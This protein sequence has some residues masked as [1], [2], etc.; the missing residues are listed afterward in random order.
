VI[1]HQEVMD[2]SREFGLGPHVIEKD[3]VLGWILAGIA[4]HAAINTT[5]VFKGGTCLKK[6][7]FETYRFSEDLDFTITKTANLD[8]DFLKTTFSEIVDWVYGETGIEIPSDRLRFDVY[9]N[10]RGKQAIEG[11]IYYRGPLQRRGDMA[12]IK[13]DISND[14]ILVLDAVHREVHH[15]YSDRPVDGIH[16]LSYCFEEVF[17]E[18]IRALGERERPR[19]LYDVVHL[20]RHD[21]MRPDRDLVKNTLQQKCEFKG[22]DVPTM[23]ALED[24]PNKAE[25]IGEWENMLAHQLPALPPFEDFWNEIPE[26]FSWLHEATEKV[27]PTPFPS[28]TTEEDDWRPPRMGTAWRMTAPLEIIRFAAANRLCVKL[29]YKGSFRLIEPYSLR[30]TK[31][32][33]I[34]LHAVRHE[35]GAPRSYRVD[36]IQSAEATKTTFKPRYEI[37]LAA[38]GPLSTPPISRQSG[39]QRVSRSGGVKTFSSLPSRRRRPLSQGPTYVIECPYCRKRFYRKKSGTRLNKHKDKHGYPCSGRIGHQ[40]DVRY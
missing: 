38:T 8:Q 5:W 19:D 31:D 3:Y 1:D 27:A 36:R 6:C 13:L 25:L 17:A 10:P 37:E 23:G 16:I 24:S 28:R 18:K 4:N 26:V 32:N 12:R 9:D 35:T 15:P 11:R 22:V 39:I 34:L 29:G 7:F 20:Y 40:V 30:R 14:E 33:N 21:D 2:F